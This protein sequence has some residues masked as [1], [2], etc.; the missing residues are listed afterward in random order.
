MKRMGGGKSSI[1]TPVKSLTGG[2]KGMKLG[3][4]RKM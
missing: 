3:G 4:K 2:G 1:K